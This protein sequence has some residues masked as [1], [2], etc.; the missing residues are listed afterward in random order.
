MHGNSGA[1]KSSPAVPDPVESETVAPV[2]E[3][4]LTE[5]DHPVASEDTLSP[6]ETGLTSGLTSGPETESDKTD[7]DAPPDEAAAQGP[8]GATTDDVSPDDPATVDE[9]ELPGDA[10]IDVASAEEDDTLAAED[11]QPEPGTPAAT[12]AAE[13]QIIKETVVERKGG[14]VQMVLGGVVAAG[15]GFVAGSYPDLP[16][17]GSPEVVE[18]PFVTETKAALRAQAEG[19][20]AASALAGANAT[21][22]A[23]IDL[24]PLSAS[25]SGIEGQLSAL[26]TTVAG[27]SEQI[28]AVDTQFTGFDERIAT[29]EKQPLIDAVSPETIA[30]YERELARLQTEVAAQQAAIAA[31]QVEQQAAVDAARAEIEAVADRARASEQSAESRAKL[32]AS[33]AALADLTTRARDGQPYAASLA[34][35]VANGVDVPAPLAEGAEDGLPTAS[36]LLTEFPQA[37]R[38]ALRVARTLQA[39]SGETGGL[40]GFLQSQ[41]GARS[42]TPRDGDDPDAVLSRAEAA[43]RGGDLDAVLTEIAALPA[44][45]QTELSEWVKM[46]QLRRDALAAAATLTQDLNKE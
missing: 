6:V 34:V 41:L 26:Q 16:F 10:G 44:A 1:G 17:M 19:I 46:A 18:D 23:A 5:I 32:A 22:V 29:L 8:E 11:Q 31:A 7:D 25:I 42:V 14:L 37:A 13:P 30:A 38:D 27:L 2:G 45:A 39:D 9:A 33:R 40:S 20:Q 3:D 12:P 4:S 43:L 28:T 24:A 36:T 15:L 35:M 21:A